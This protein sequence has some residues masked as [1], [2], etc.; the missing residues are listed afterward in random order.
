MRSLPLA[1]ARPLRAGIN[2]TAGSGPGQSP[3]STSS[4]DCA[5]GYPQAIRSRHPAARTLPGRDASGR[6]IQCR[7]LAREARQHQPP[8]DERRLGNDVAVGDPPADGAVGLDRERLDLGLDDHVRQSRRAE[9]GDQRGRGAVRPAERP[10]PALESVGDEPVLRRPAG[11]RRPRRAPAARR[12]WP[13]RD[14]PSTPRRARRFGARPDRARSYRRPTRSVPD[15]RACRPPLTGRRPRS[16][17]ASAPSAIGRGGRPDSA[18]VASCGGAGVGTDGGDVDGHVASRPALS[19][20]TLP[21]SSVR[22]RTGRSRPSVPRRIRRART[23]G[24]AASP[25]GDRRPVPR[26]SGRPSR[27]RGSGACPAAPGRPPSACP[28]AAQT[29]GKRPRSGSMIVRIGRG[30]AD[31]RDAA[32]R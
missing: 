5:R 7:H 29:T 14:A 21:R 13:M 19:A 2:A 22:R 8:P 26:R 1:C 28:A 4:R 27:W 9:H 25:V 32:D 23:S 11:P 17:T 30:V 24:A 15:P 18:T 20:V 6:G 16:L 12:R 3:L 31:R 10:G